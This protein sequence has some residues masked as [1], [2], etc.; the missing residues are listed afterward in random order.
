[1]DNSIT[2]PFEVSEIFSIF[3]CEN[4]TVEIYFYSIVFGTL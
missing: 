4:N 2:F 1:M 3:M